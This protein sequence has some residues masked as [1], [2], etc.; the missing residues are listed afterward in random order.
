MV[1]HILVCPSHRLACIATMLVSW[2]SGRLKERTW[3]MTISTL[4]AVAGFIVATSVENTAGRYAGMIIFC[5]GTYGV[6]SLMLG[7]CGSVCGQMREKKS[8]GPGTYP[9]NLAPVRRASINS[10]DRLVRLPREM[11]DMVVDHLDDDSVDRLT[12]TS[13][14]LQNLVGSRTWHK[15]EVAC[16][17]LSD[18]EK[19]IWRLE[20]CV[21]GKQKKM[22]TE[23][24]AYPEHDFVDNDDIPCCASYV[25]QYIIN[26]S[27]D[28]ALYEEPLINL[29]GRDTIPVE[30][31]QVTGLVHLCIYNVECARFGEDNGVTLRML[32]GSATTLR[33]LELFHYHEQCS[34]EVEV[35]MDG[36]DFQLTALEFLIM[37]RFCLREAKAMLQVVDFPSLA[38]LHIYQPP[39]ELSA[40]FVTLQARF[41]AVQQPTLRLLELDLNATSDQAMFDAQRRWLRSFTTLKSLRLDRWAPQAPALDFSRALP[42]IVGHQGLRK[43]IFSH[44]D[45][46]RDSEGGPQF[47]IPVL[48]TASVL[49]LALNLPELRWLE[50]AP[51]RDDLFETGRALSGLTKLEFMRCRHQEDGDFNYVFKM[52]T[53]IIQGFLREMQPD[54]TWEGKYS[55][56]LVQAEE[57]GVQY[58]VAS[59][60]PEAW[61]RKRIITNPTTKKAVRM[62]MARDVDPAFVEDSDPVWIDKVGRDW[63]VADE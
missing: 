27:D 62:R 37:C 48:K 12:Q 54:E 43:L 44:R 13:R 49:T 53:K 16:T 42:S 61:G 22:L 18:Q 39:D 24:G 59:R 47:Y 3:H 30:M 7:R 46:E 25:R 14:T 31:V 1:G 4:V 17:N 26:G 55:L 21:T 45:R 9:A 40:F 6:N 32:G 56:R 50:F 15:V 33:S 60:L 10:M 41:G 51:D 58:D 52:L 28:Q 36:I 2:S 57:E 5:N 11:L 63:R 34:E 23:N 20:A 29:Y 38:E 19:L 8:A 35:Q